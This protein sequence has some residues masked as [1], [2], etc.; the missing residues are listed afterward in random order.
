MRAA[1]GPDAIR[2]GVSVTDPVDM[3]VTV[4]DPTVWITSSFAPAWFQ[5]ALREARMGTDHTARRSEIVF[6]VCFAESYL[7]EWVRDAVLKGRMEQLST[8]FPPGE[9]IG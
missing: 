2:S 3:V 1:R 5:D 4:H 7:V 9:Q 6:A 8:Y